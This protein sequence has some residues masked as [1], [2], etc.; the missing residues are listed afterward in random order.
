MP[1]SNVT[2]ESASAHNSEMFK[3]LPADVLACVVAQMPTDT[4][5]AFA[6]TCRAAS[7]A[8][9]SETHWHLRFK[10]RAVLVANNVHCL[11]VSSG[12]HGNNS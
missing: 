2:A 8:V 6:R 11:S 7:Q 3:L 10:V 4:M 12:E 1:D 9:A 5:K